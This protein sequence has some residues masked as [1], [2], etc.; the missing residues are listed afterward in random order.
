MPLFGGA[1]PSDGLEARMAR[2]ALD[3]QLRHQQDH[4]PELLVDD[5]AG[6]PVLETRHDCDE[7]ALPPT[8]SHRRRHDRSPTLDRLEVLNK[9]A[10]KMDFAFIWIFAQSILFHILNWRCSLYWLP[11]INSWFGG[12][13]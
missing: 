12:L 6:E 2:E 7:E 1:V 8:T 10:N 9:V 13:L 5:V 4:R 3:Q 11:Y